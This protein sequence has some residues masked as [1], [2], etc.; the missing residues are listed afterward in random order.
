M[1][2]NVGCDKKIKKKKKNI[3]YLKDFIIKMLKCNCSIEKKLQFMIS[4]VMAGVLN[5]WMQAMFT[6]HG[7]ILY[8]VDWSKFMINILSTF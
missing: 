8:E 1:Y 2:F 6:I 4:L 7:Y 3:L 5:P